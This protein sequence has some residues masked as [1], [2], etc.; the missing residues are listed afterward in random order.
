MIPPILSY[1]FCPTGLT[2]PRLGVWC[3]PHRLQTLLSF[4]FL[5][6]HLPTF[7]LFLAPCLKVSLPLVWTLPYFWPPCSD[8]VQSL[9]SWVADL[10]PSRPRASQ[11][12]CPKTVEPRAELPGCP[13]PGWCPEWGVP[14]QP[15]EAGLW[16]WRLRACDQTL[17]RRGLPAFREARCSS[18]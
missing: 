11:G 8:I 10:P 14:G 3:V 4:F 2:L 7:L 16:P 12:T 9:G 15:R 6:G 17:P 1:A 13:A 5:H 18:C